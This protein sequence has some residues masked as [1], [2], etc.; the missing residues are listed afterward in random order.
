MRWLVAF[1]TERFGQFLGKL[2]PD[3]LS[4]AGDHAHRVDQLIRRAF[5]GQVT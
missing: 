2:W 1:V 5:L 3:I 4:A